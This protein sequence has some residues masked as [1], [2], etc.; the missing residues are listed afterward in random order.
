[1]V[2]SPLR[3]CHFTWR[4]K[5]QAP[6]RG[7]LHREPAGRTATAFT[8]KDAK[9]AQDVHGA[10]R[11]T[12]H[13]TRADHVPIRPFLSPFTLIRRPP[14]LALLAF[15]AVKDVVVPSRTRTRPAPI[16]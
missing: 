14:S 6:A 16:G 4:K 7:I 9:D 2:R 12:T 13:D 15:L 3:T 10:G 1:M 11:G 8:A 5:V